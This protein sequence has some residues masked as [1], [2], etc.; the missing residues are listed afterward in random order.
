M[1]VSNFGISFGAFML[2]K[3]DALGGLPSIFII[4]GAGLSVALL[5]LLTA[6]FPRR[7]EYYEIQKRREIM[8]AHKPA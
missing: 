4:V 6:K 5:L 3:T 8:A 7:P 2:G 1:A